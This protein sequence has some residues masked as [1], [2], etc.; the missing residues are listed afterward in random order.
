MHSAGSQQL[1]ELLDNVNHQ[2]Q[3]PADLDNL[4]KVFKKVTKPELSI[5]D[6]RGEGGKE[7]EET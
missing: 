6:S 5:H 7:V 4:S 2:Q 3:V 1:P